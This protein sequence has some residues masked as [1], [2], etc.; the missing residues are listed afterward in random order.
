MPRNKVVHYQRLRRPGANYSLEFVFEDLRRRLADKITIE[1]VIAPCVSKG[2]VRRLI[3]AIHAWFSQGKITHITGDITFAGIL[4]NPNKTVITVLDCGI[5]HRKKGFAKWLIKK[6][7]FDWPM[8]RCRWITTISNAAADDIVSQC[9]VDRKKIRV[10]PVAISESFQFSEKDFHEECPRILQVGTAPNKN[11]DRVIEALEGIPCTFV[12]IGR[13]SNSV[14]NS[15]VSRKIA[16]EN[17]HSL[18]H[19][20]VIEQYRKA[21]ML[22]FVSTYEGFGMP[23]LEAQTTGRVVVTSDCCSMPEVAGGGALL[24]D[25]YSVASIR[26]AIL[27]AIQNA[28]LRK[29]LIV[30]G[31]E[32]SRRFRGEEIALR[33]EKLYESFS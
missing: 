14:R 12:I 10:I 13:L 3:I 30:K 23:I 33:F 11:V 19:E 9:S 32:N 8:S 16:V 28:S 24:A 4:L 2:L 26:K 31:L 7:W 15:I 17:Y 22:C 25:P 18:S 20:E 27:S 6:L 21:D 5:L 1:P 29:E